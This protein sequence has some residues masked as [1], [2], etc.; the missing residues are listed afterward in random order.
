MWSM[1]CRIRSSRQQECKAW[2]CVLTICATACGRPS[3]AASAFGTKEGIGHMHAP[4]G[5]QALG[6]VRFASDVKSISSHARIFLPPSHVRLQ[7]ALAAVS[8]NN[9]Y[10]LLVCSADVTFGWKVASPAA[11]KFSHAAWCL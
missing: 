11:L 3:D 10:S 4:T 9:I 2:R 5:C 7:Q 1:R 6:I 8:R